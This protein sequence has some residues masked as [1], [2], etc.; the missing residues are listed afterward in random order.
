MLFS[1]A[2][3]GWGFCRRPGIDKFWQSVLS[4]AFSLRIMEELPYDWRDMAKS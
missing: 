3:K 4:A 2:H 1:K